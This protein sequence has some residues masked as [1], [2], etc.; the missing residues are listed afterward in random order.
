VTVLSTI[1]MIAYPLFGN[2]SRLI[3]DRGFGEVV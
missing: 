3:F 1:A 2:C